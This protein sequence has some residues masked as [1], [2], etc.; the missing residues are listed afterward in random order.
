MRT[1]ARGYGVC[2]PGTGGGGC[3]WWLPRFAFCWKRG[4]HSFSFLLSLLQGLTHSV[5]S[6][7]AS[8][9]GSQLLAGC[10][11][12]TD[13]LIWDVDRLSVCRVLRAPSLDTSSSSCLHWHPQMSLIATGAKYSW[14]Y[15]WDPRTSSPVATLQPHRGA[16][17][18]VV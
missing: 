1:G 7:S 12:G 15:L 11:D 9:Q 2:T 10:S 8:P 3:S 6:L 4:E 18:K 17:N 16:I 5:L 14:L 13:P